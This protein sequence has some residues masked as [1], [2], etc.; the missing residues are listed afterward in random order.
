MQALSTVT[1]YNCKLRNAEG[2]E[3]RR[4]SA[5]QSERLAAEMEEQREATLRTISAN[6]N[7]RLATDMEVQ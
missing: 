7:R 2:A 1:T 4:V 6:Q 5:R 3:V